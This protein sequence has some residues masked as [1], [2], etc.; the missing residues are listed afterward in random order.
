MCVHHCLISELSGIAIGLAD[1]WQSAISGM[2]YLCCSSVKKLTCRLLLTAACLNRVPQPLRNGN[3]QRSVNAQ[4]NGARH[5]VST[6]PVTSL[7][8]AGGAVQILHELLS[9]DT[10]MPAAAITRVTTELCTAQRNGD[11]Q[12]CQEILTNAIL[13]FDADREALDSTLFDIFGTVVQCARS[14]Q[15]HSL[16]QQYLQ[17]VSDNCSGREVLTLLMSALDN[18]SG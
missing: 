3:C 13:A 17:L 2:R 1:Q 14:A 10:N 8:P 6:L 7:V 18:T 16:V 15:C 4:S 12:L 11:W 9:A 5:A